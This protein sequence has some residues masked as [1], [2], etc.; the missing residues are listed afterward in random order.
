[1]RSGRADVVS[2]TYG[3]FEP[4]SNL[5]KRIVFIEKFTGVNQSRICCSVN[6]SM[7]KLRAKEREL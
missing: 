6:V 5:Y 4:F 1:M 3:N 7:M 2:I